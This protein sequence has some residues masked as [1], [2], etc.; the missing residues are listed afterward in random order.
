MPT[1]VT[2][3]QCPSCTGPLHFSGETGKLECDYCGSSFEVA[4]IEALYAERSEEASEQAAAD[5]IE[6]EAAEDFKEDTDDEIEAQP[7]SDW[8][9]DAEKVRAYN[10]P[11]CGAELICDASTAATSCPYCGNPSIIPGQLGGALKPDYVIPF[12][13]DKAAA[14]AALKK[15][16]KGKHLLPNTF[17]KTN[18]IEKIQGVYVPFWLFDG[19]AD[20]DAVFRCKR[21][22]VVRSDDQEITTT[23]H[24]EVCRGGTAEFQRIPVDGSK[25]MPDGHMDAIEPFDYAELTEFSTAYLPGYLADRYD[26]SAKQ[27]AERA[28]RRMEQS[29]MDELRG[30]ITGYDSVKV[31]SKSIK[32]RQ[33]KAHY[34]LLPVWML[35]TEWKGNRYLFAMNGQTGKLA[36][37]LP[38]SWKKFWGYFLAIVAGVSALLIQLFG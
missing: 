11:S 18:Q 6:A 25:K 20:A 3:Y 28:R 19:S 13:L 9:A 23:Q 32:I 27:S 2:N 34:A 10:C 35:Y 30:T 33:G 38:V 21:V 8:G 29:M 26:V 14:V 5:A 31:E 16:Y 24:Y 36:G 15:F 17:T 37:D 12:Q 22:T 7:G 4:E 1:Q